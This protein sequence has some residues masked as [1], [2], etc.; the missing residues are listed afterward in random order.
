MSEQGEGST[1]TNLEEVFLSREF[2]PAPFRRGPADGRFGDGAEAPQL[3]EDLLSEDFA[4]APALEEV[5]LSETFGRPRVVV[6]RR[7]HG[8]PLE[9][10]AP[11]DA[12]VTPLRPTQESTRYRA[13]AAVS[14]VAA[15]ALVVVGVAS[16]G[17]AGRPSVS[18]QGVRVSAQQPQGGGAPGDTS[19]VPAVT[20]A[21]AP[22][23]TTVAQ[24]GAG[25]ASFAGPAANT[26]VVVST[27]ALVA[28]TP[29]GTTPSRSPASTSGSPTST[30]PTP[31]AAPTDPLAPVVASI[32]TTVSGQG[33][34]VTST[35]SQIGN[36]LQPV[37]P[38][39]ALL[40]S[41]GTTLTSIGHAMRPAS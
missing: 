32:G 20:S 2:G 10:V 29:S 14:G 36:A 9:L 3:E 39:T 30:P 19:P 7:A 40:G 28:G 24:S 31:P 38:I 1:S 37:A 33:T 4:D 13:I 18:A 15:A 6:P 27:A 17:H 22:V 35:V 34:T 12:V 23:D 16:G 21:T 26:G 11:H 5:F 8:A 41:T 25:G